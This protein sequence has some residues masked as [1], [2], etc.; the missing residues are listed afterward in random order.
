MKWRIKKLIAY[1][2][3]RNFGFSNHQASYIKRTIKA[4]NQRH[5]LKEYYWPLWCSYTAGASNNLM[6][7]SKQKISVKNKNSTD[8]NRTT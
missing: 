4:S 8:I 2:L 7:T 1:L 5:C 3:K 6:N